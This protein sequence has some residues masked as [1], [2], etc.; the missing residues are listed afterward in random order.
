MGECII[1]FSLFF[2]IFQIF[3]NCVIFSSNMQSFLKIHP[4][5]DPLIFIH[6]TTSIPHFFILD[7]QFFSKYFIHHATFPPKFHPS[8]MLASPIS[9]PKL[10]ASWPVNVYLS[11]LGQPYGTKGND[12]LHQVT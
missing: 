10:L 3:V 5:T 9:C 4:I 8:S 6:Y 2:I 12:W 11:N 1:S 7:V